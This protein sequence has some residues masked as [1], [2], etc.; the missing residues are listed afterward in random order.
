MVV[1]F[2][3]SESA[4]KKICIIYYLFI[5]KSFN[6]AISNWNYTVWNDWRVNNEL[7]RMW[8]EYVMAWHLPGWTA[9]NLRQYSWHPGQDLKPVLPIYKLEALLLEWTWL[10]TVHVIILTIKCWIC[11]ILP[12]FHFLKKW[13]NE[14]SST[15]RAERFTMIINSLL[16][17]ENK[18]TVLEKQ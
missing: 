18:S 3:L 16:K 15:T 17:Y 13:I 6:D 9:Y 8:K 2:H 7:E 10:V 11:F 4:H 1:R 12:D 14:V 5:C